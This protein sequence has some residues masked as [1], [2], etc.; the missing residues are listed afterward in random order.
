[1]RKNIIDASNNIKKLDEMDSYFSENYEGELFNVYAEQMKL[2]PSFV[3]FFN[4]NNE[5]N[6][7]ELLIEH[8]TVATTID[9]IKQD[10][11]LQP[12]KEDEAVDDAIEADVQKIGD[13]SVEK[14][15]KFIETCADTCAETAYSPC[16]YF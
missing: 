14:I 5:A 6:F 1:M 3:N 11:I 13:G 9:K 4:M 16:I 8:D 10:G 7:D 12:E 2:K 15:E